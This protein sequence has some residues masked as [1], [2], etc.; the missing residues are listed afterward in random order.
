MTANLSLS[1]DKNI[2][3]TVSESALRKQILMLALKD[4]GAKI[5]VQDLET[6]F[7]IST[8]GMSD[9]QFED[10]IR[11]I[12]GV[13]DEIGIKIQVDKN[14]FNELKKIQEEDEI[15]LRECKAARDVWDGNLDIPEFKKFSKSVQE[16]ISAKEF[17]DG[18]YTKQLL[19]SYHLAASGSACNFS[20]PGAG[21]TVN[22]WAAYSYLNSLPKNNPRHKCDFCYW[23]KSML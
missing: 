3:L 20:V 12:Q 4:W 21:K 14:A 9:F 18:L 22:V 16:N 2:F 7:I 23:A 8:Q 10:T 13:F 19:A 17:P 6:T 11:D 15:F 1:D 5:S